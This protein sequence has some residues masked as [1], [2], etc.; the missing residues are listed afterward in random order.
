MSDHLSPAKQRTLPQVLRIT[1]VTVFALLAISL[2]QAADPMDTPSLDAA[3]DSSGRFRVQFASESGCYYKLVRIGQPVARSVVAIASG[4]GSQLVLRD[5]VL[6]GQ[7]TLYNVVITPDADASDTDGDG[8]SDAVELVNYPANNP[9]N[10]GRSIPSNDGAIA[11]PDR[12][13]FEFLARRDDVPGA[14]NVREVKFLMFG[15]D[16]D[17]PTIHFF[18]SNRHL[19]HF[20]FARDVLGY[21]AGM[22]LVLVEA[23]SV[24]ELPATGTSQV[25][26]GN[27]NGKL[28]FRVFDSQR[29]TIDDV[30]ED[31][32]RSSK[33]SLVAALKDDLAPYWESGISS[34]ELQRETILK[35][36]VIVENFLFTPFYAE[37][38]FSNSQRKNVAGS[39]IAHDSY[40]GPNGRAGIYTMEFWPTDPVEFRF[41]EKAYHALTTAM[42]FVDSQVVYHPASETQRTIFNIEREQFE[43]SYVRSISTQELFGNV[44]YTA[45]NMGVG[46]GLLRVAN[47]GETLTARDLVIFRSLPNDLTHV[48]GIITEIP[49]TPLSHVNLKAIQNNTPNAYIKDAETD[50]NIAPLIGKYVR[51]E[52]TA[53]GY[54]IREATQEEVDSFLEDLRPAE[55]Q[56]PIRNLSATD[57]LPLEKLVLD[58]SSAYGAKVANLAELR[59]MLPSEMTPDGFGVPF[60]F[61]DS[62]MEANGFYE[63]A[64]TMID[65][66]DFKADPAIR[67]ARLKEFRSKIKSGTAPQWMMDAVKALQDSFPAGTGIRCRSST[68]NEDLEDFNGAGLYDSYTHHPDEGHLIKSLRQVWA[69][70]WTYRA[71]EERD[72]YRIDHFTAAMGVL[73]HPNYEHEQANGVAVTKNIVNPSWPGIY[74]NVQ[75]G[76]DLVTNPEDESVPEE[77][78]IAQLNPDD[79][80]AYEIQYV[81]FSNR[82][83]EGERVITPDQAEELAGRLETVQWGFRKLYKAQS[84]PDFAMEVEF[85]ITEEGNLIIKQARPWLE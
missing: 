22:S 57:I 5:P 41:V 29:R 50:S 72:F 67:E 84:D 73:V 14:Q 53:D 18:N 51:Y 76:E 13:T 30:G 17:S 74:V 77:F 60:Y 28:H 59:R 27:I 83:P 35:V 78:L 20:S 71:F 46:Y 26:I 23:D 82:L 52:V 31:L 69:G 34:E 42:P 65:A 25:I 49:Q 62:F 1:A 7:D 38:Y 70:M 80:S 16:T 6:P 68:N 8:I 4:T 75:V 45:M 40:V 55:P 54:E 24:S 32:L 47:A 12:A 15:V 21:T 19:Y 37:T 44:T 64:Q 9:L 58:S 79:W 48:A 66:A 3:L 63:M 11:I 2:A 39:L 85:K 10:P 36:N 56:Y 81:R 61:Y 43:A 33:K